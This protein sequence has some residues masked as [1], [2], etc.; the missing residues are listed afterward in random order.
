MNKEY[1]YYNYS[2]AI[3]KLYD[4]HILNDGGFDERVFLRS[5]SNTEIGTPQKC[6]LSTTAA[7]G[8]VGNIVKRRSLNF[9]VSVEE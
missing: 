5:D 7:T 9:G 3:N 4:E 2:K 8:D 1:Y 6:V